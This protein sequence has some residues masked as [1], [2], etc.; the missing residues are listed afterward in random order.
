VGLK[1]GRFDGED[2]YT[3][4]ESDRLVRLPMYYGMIPE[5]AQ[6]VIQAVLGFFHP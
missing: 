5:D 1:Y 6:Q 4:R 3:T 2:V